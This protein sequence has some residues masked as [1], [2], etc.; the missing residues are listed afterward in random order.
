[1]FN[2]SRCNLELLNTGIHEVWEK[3]LYLGWDYIL[4]RIFIANNFLNI[5]GKFIEFIICI[6]VMFRGEYF[7][8]GCDNHHGKVL[9]FG[10]FAE[11]F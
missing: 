8:L 10:K 7:S 3:K 2:N 1:M 4:I 6:R 5:S 11:K 9:K